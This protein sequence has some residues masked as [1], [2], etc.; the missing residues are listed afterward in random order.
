MKIWIYAASMLLGALM[1]TALVRT[2]GDLSGSR[3]S[4]ADR[5]DAARKKS[6]RGPEPIGVRIGRMIAAET[7]AM[8]E[9]VPINDALEILFNEKKSP[10][11]TRAFLKSRIQTMTRDQLKQALMN[12]EIQT[13]SEIREAARRLTNEDPDGTFNDLNSHV[14]KLWGMDNRY[15]FIDTMLQTSADADAPAV[16]RRLQQMKRGG[17]QMDH[18]LR[19]S[20]YWA[21]VDPAA[22]ARNFSDL[23]YLRNMSVQGTTVF[24]D[25][26]YAESIVTSWKRKDEEAM[27]A[28]IGNLPPGKERDAFESA[29]KKHDAPK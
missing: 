10:L 5:A 12:G 11:R 14:Y 13:D 23:V 20:N 9:N 19:F 7:P 16:M 27:R 26:T 21:N 25:K 4:A 22:A 17:S 29:L 6:A 18:S 2:V 1:G 8:D 3:A 28:Y 15:A 24:T